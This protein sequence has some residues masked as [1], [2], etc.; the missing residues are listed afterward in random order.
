MV[1]KKNK[2]ISNRQ[3]RELDLDAPDF[4]EGA[5]EEE[6]SEEQEETKPA[7]PK[8]RL[9]EAYQESIEDL[10]RRQDAL[11]IPATKIDKPD[12]QEDIEDLKERVKIIEGYMVKQ[13]NY[14]ATLHDNFKILLEQNE[15]S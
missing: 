5:E 10:K 6:Q 12:N 8:E 3:M 1:L 14:I 4:E 15:S 11:D 7:S 13:H 9:R 2:T